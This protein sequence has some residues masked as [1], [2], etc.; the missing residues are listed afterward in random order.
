MR[1]QVSYCMTGNSEP[2]EKQEGAS[3]SGG[4]SGRYGGTTVRRYSKLCR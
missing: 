2:E 1:R 3:F 4:H